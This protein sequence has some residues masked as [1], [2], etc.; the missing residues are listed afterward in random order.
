MITSEFDE[1]YSRFFI[2]VKDYDMAGYDENLAK[3]V[4]NGYVRSTL[5]KPIVRRLF[6]AIVVDDELGEIEY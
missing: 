2:R 6:S 4:L 3:E 1:I 5:S